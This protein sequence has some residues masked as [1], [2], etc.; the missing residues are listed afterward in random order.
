L[1][2]KE[3]SATFGKARKKKERRMAF[4]IRHVELG[5]KLDIKKEL[6]AKCIQG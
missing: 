5:K 6:H 3:E 4:H 1:S 2:V